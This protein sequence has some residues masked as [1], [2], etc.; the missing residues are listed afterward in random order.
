MIGTRFY[1]RMGNVLF[2]A[3]HTIA[4]A[5]KNNQEFSFPNR[6]Q[7]PYWNPLYLQHLVNEKYEQGREDILINEPHYHYAPLEYKKE[8]DGRQVVLNGYWQSEKYFKDFRNEIIYLFGYPYSI[9]EDICSIH[10][11][12]GDYLMLPEK[13]ILMNEGYLKIAMNTITAKTGITRFKVFSDDIHYFKTNLGRLSDFEYSANGNEVSDMIEM[14]CCHSNINSS[15][16][17]AWWGSWL[18]KNPDKVVVTPEKWFQD[19]WMNM[20]TKDVIP[21]TW[22]KL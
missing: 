14:S 13:H 3:A 12:Y 8:W 19:G 20:N 9:K 4:F 6:T 17:F 15:S 21:D 7:D 2:Q 16:T 11:R 5:L 10:A 18:N 1:G 22:I